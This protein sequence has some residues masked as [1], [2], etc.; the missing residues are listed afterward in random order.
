MDHAARSVEIVVRWGA[1]VLRVAR[2]TP[3]RSFL[4]GDDPY[5]PLDCA[6]PKALLG[7]SRVPVVFVD[8]LGAVWLVEPAGATTTLDLDGASDD[9]RRVKAFPELPGARAIPMPLGCKATL[10]IG[11]IVVEVDH[12]TAIKAPAVA[13]LRRSAR[14]PLLHVAASFA[15]HAALLLA[16]AFAMPR[17]AETPESIVEAPDLALVSMI[18][19][20]DTSGPPEVEDEPATELAESWADDRN[21]SRSRCGEVLGGS[22]GVASAERTHGRYGVAGPA[23]NP[24][25]HLARNDFPW[26]QVEGDIVGP[27]QAHDAS[28]DPLGPHAPWG[29]DEA[30]GNDPRSARGE[31]WGDAITASYGSPG[32]GSGRNALCTTCGDTGMGV[33]LR[34]T[35]ALGGPI[36]TELVGPV[37]SSD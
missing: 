14:R 28:G 7:A 22:M 10:E 35:T 8:E 36:G 37:A 3:P 9:A 1:S 2:L 31:M 15:A 5:E 11:E 26:T 25:P 4:L 16:S 17:L 34:L 30:L 29:R 23:D 24:D 12:A 32:L 20:D 6:I 19:T 33:R 13:L 27:M 18:A 21:P